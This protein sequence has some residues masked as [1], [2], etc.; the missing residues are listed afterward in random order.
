M[1][2]MS[3]LSLAIL[4]LLVVISNY[5]I[6]QWTDT[7]D[8]KEIT[9]SSKAVRSLTVPDSAGFF[10]IFDSDTNLKKFDFNGFLLSE[11][12]LNLVYDNFMRFSSDGKSYITSLNEYLFPLYWNDTLSVC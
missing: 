11:R 2:T 6:S 5:S 7:G 8:Y 1:K 3:F 4:F 9:A 10:Y 12:K